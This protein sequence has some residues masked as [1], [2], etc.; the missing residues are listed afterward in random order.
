MY[1]K[2]QQPKRY[3]SCDI[4]YYDFLSTSITTNPIVFSLLGNDL[5]IFKFQ[6]LILKTGFR[7]FF[8]PYIPITAGILFVMN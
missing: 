6:I 1:M 7:L 5:R 8:C 4:K 2:K 3:P